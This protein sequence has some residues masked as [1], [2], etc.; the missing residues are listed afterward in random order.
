[1]LI[2][3]WILIP[4]RLKNSELGQDFRSL[5]FNLRGEELLK[6]RK[7]NI[8]TDKIGFDLKKKSF[9]KKCFKNGY[10][11]KEYKGFVTCY[12]VARS[13]RNRNDFLLTK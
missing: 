1:M 13:R 10:Y 8:K 12:S 6:Q 2:S 5:L 3:L 11:E 4:S 7:K 9:Y